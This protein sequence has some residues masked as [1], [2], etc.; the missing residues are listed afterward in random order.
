MTS[1]PNVWQSKRA[2]VEAGQAVGGDLLG[3]LG[4]PAQMGLH[5]GAIAGVAIV[6]PEQLVDAL[7]IGRVARAGSLFGPGHFHPAA[8]WCH[9]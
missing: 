2:E 4:L 1:S 6:V 5:R 8:E 9:Q 3:K 7:G